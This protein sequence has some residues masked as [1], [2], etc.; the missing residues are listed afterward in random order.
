M[1]GSGSFFNQSKR[2]IVTSRIAILGYSGRQPSAK[3]V[4]LPSTT[5]APA[6]APIA[7]AVTPSTN[8]RMPGRL[9]YFLK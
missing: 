5:H 1:T 8:A 4:R 9:P 6:I 7:A 2:P 3:I